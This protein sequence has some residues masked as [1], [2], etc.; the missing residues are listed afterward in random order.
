MFQ[1]VDMNK[2]GSDQLYVPSRSHEKRHPTKF[3]VLMKV[4]ATSHTNKVKKDVSD[5]YVAWVTFHGACNCD[6]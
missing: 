4:G 3:Q 1:E 2:G 5:G 6:L